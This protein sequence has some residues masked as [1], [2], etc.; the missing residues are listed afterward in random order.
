MNFVLSLGKTVA[1][2]L[3]QKVKLYVMEWANQNAYN[4]II[5]EYDSKI[6]V[7]MIKDNFNIFCPMK[8]LIYLIKDFAWNLHCKVQ[9]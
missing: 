3:K 4:I 5:L 6:M 9:H 2:W 8:D 7:E 1:I